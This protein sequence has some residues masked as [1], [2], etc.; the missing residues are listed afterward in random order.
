M[1]VLILFIFI[2]QIRETL[3][4]Q[5]QMFTTQSASDD[6]ELNISS[7]EETNNDSY[8]STNTSERRGGRRGRGNRG[9]RTT[10]RSRGGRA[11]GQTK[12]NF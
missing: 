5:P 2:L 8:A 6:D 9:P 4:S 10:A 12:L 11:K 1:T 3:N 7:A